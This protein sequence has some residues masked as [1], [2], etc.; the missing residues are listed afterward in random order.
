M[1]VKAFAAD[2]SNLMMYVC[3]DRDQQQTVHDSS[4]WPE[5]TQLTIIT[6]SH[7][8]Q[9]CSS[10]Q[11]IIV[12]H[13]PGAADSVLQSRQ[14]WQWSTIIFSWEKTQTTHTTPHQST[15][16]EQ[17]FN[18]SELSILSDLL[19]STNHSSASLQQYCSWEEHT[20]QSETSIQS[21]D[22][23]ATNHSL[24]LLLPV[25]QHG[26]SGEQHQWWWRQ[27]GQ[28]WGRLLL[29]WCHVIISLTGDQA[30]E[31]QGRQ[32][33]EFACKVWNWKKAI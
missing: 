11:E 7:S 5:Q 27:C 26:V 24:G 25:V 12:S 2:Q 1:A 28:Q 32:C 29:Q 31:H 33:L 13:D 9:H 17:W 4:P 18:Q 21:C 15:S 10:P 30:S 6:M 8:T 19:L 16:D 20:D 14:C 3:S 23:Q 22:R